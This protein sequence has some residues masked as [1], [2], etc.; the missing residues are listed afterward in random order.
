MARAFAKITFTSSARAMQD[1]QGVGQACKRF[2]SNDIDRRDGFVCPVRGGTR[3]W[4]LT[5]KQWTTECAGCCQQTSGH[6]GRAAFRSLLGSA[7]TKGP[8]TYDMLI[9]PGAK[10]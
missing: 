2:L 5:T 6:R 7:T 9:A 1:R 10:G 8:I 4:A 3:G